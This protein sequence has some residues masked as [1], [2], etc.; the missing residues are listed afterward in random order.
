MKTFGALGHEA[1]QTFTKPQNLDISQWKTNTSQ[2][3]LW[4]RFK[5]QKYS[6]N[7]KQKLK[8]LI[9]FILP[10]KLV[11]GSTDKVRRK[12]IQFGAVKT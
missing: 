1:A 5:F 2:D 4:K 8:L 10:M 6:N 12:K 9:V 11:S 7:H 3:S